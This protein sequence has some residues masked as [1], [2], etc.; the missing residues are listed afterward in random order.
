MHEISNNVVCGP[1]KPQISLRIRAVWSEPLQVGWVFYECKATDR[2]SFGVSKLKRRLHKLNWVF[3]IV[4]AQLLLFNSCVYVSVFCL[5]VV[6]IFMFGCSSY[7]GGNIEYYYLKKWFTGDGILKKPSG[8]LKKTLLSTKILVCS[9]LIGLT[10]ILL[11][12]YIE[13]TTIPP[14][15]PSIDHLQTPWRQQG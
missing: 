13:A 7:I 2:T 5:N 8:R 10:S 14:P 15:P 9:Q 1:S 11:A 3:N 4:T 12:G 6:N